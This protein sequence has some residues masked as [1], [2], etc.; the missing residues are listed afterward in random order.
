MAQFSFDIVSE[1]DRSEINNVFEQVQREIGNRYDFK[2]TP[3]AVEWLGDKTG[4]KIIAAG[5]WQLEA[6][7]DIVRKKLASRGQSTKVLDLSKDPIT[8]NLKTTQDIPFLSGIS[9]DNAKQISKLIRDN[10]PKA[11]PQIQGEVVRVVSAS[12]NDLQA[13]MRLLENHDFSFA[14]SFTN[15]R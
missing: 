7:I 12:K 11:K 9:Q 3:A 4:F 13:V 1:Y 10:F 5:D 14:T 2:N 8:S 15:F 6:V